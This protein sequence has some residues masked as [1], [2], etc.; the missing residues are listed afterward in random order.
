MIDSKALAKELKQ[1]R[2]A[3]AAAEDAWCDVEELLWNV[4]RGPRYWRRIALEAATDEPVSLP[5]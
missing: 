2:S 4:Q 1:A 3:R 5:H